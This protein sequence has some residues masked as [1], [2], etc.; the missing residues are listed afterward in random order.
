MSIDENMSIEYYKKNR[1]VPTL[2]T[3]RQAFLSSNLELIQWYNSIAEEEYLDVFIPSD[4]GIQKLVKLGNLEA[5]KYFVSIGSHPP[6]K[7]TLIDAAK[8]GYPELL[9]YFSSYKKVIG[10]TELGMLIASGT[11]GKVYHD[12]NDE[13]VVVKVYPIDSGLSA[14]N[15][16]EI[17]T[18]KI[19]IGVPNTIQ[20]IDVKFDLNFYEEDG[21]PPM[22]YLPYYQNT[23]DDLLLDKILLNKLIKNKQTPI[24]IFQICNGLHGMLNRGIIHRDIK[25]ENILINIDTLELVLADFGSSKLINGEFSKEKYLT[26]MNMENTCEIQSPI[27]S[28]PET[29]AAMLNE[30]DECN[31]D[32]KLDVWSVGLI[33]RELYGEPRIQS[34]MLH[35]QL[36]LYCDI[37]VDGW[38][39]KWEPDISDLMNGM[40]QFESKDRLSIWEA[41]RMDYFKDFKPS[42]PLWSLPERLSNMDRIGTFSSDEDILRIEGYKLIKEMCEKNSTKEILFQSISIWDAYLTKSSNPEII[43]ASIA[44]YF[45]SFLYM[46]QPLY[47]EDIIISQDIKIKRNY[48]Y[49][50]IETLDF[51]LWMSSDI[52]FVKVSLSQLVKTNSIDEKRLKY[53]TSNIT[54]M[55]YDYISQLKARDIS[56]SDVVYELIS[57][58]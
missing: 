31:Y 19:L 45:A 6:T 30:Q 18:L 8:D 24:I 13:N 48:L 42:E 56:R 3:L 36:G 27:Y 49:E 4:E 52:D 40:I 39:S 21:I 35:G 22:I 26:K 20:L 11:F 16:K 32:N 37:F 50:F 55:L 33:M 10:N 58:I 53:I 38:S 34:K 51:D 57:L 54:N 47:I 5:L 44:V 15:I 43:S 28:S 25:P 7:T 17:S 1:E 46:L 14:I 12:Y 23:L 29:L 2:K 9:D 41:L